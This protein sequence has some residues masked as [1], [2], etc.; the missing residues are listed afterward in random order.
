MNTIELHTLLKSMNGFLL[1]MYV[2]QY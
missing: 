2:F 1:M